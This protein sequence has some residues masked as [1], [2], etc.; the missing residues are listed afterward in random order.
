[1][2]W[3]TARYVLLTVLGIAS[4]VACSGIAR[5]MPSVGVPVKIPHAIGELAGSWEY[6][7][8]NGTFPLVLN[9]QG[10]GPYDWKE[11]RFETIAL[12][13]GVWTGKWYQAEND[14]EG[15]FELTFLEDIPLAKG[16][17]WYTRIGSDTAPLEPGGQFSLKQ[18][19][20]GVAMEQ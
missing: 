4:L 10:Q 14:R 5:P 17:W 7:D 12:K 6:Q 1:M 13:N 11:G 3:N 19:S 9:E 2:M 18:I 15:E 8:V 20:G 16:E